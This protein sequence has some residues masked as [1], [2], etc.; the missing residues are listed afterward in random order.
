MMICSL[1]PGRVRLRSP[2]FRDAETVAAVNT[3]LKDQ[4]GF[5]SLE[6]NLN[7]GSLL[8]RFDPDQVDQEAA[9]AALTL[10]EEDDDSEEASELYSEAAGAVPFRL[11]KDA[12][13]YL[14]M[15]GAFVVCLSSGFLRSKGLHVYS[16]LTLAGLTV[17][18]VVKYRKRLAALLDRGA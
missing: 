8:I 16:G 12:A 5:I 3:L 9:L 15:I 17:Q 18:H 11:N 4:P 2:R 7:T 13:E 10:L 6:N 1:L 14:G